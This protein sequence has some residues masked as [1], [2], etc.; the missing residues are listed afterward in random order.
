[1]HEGGIRVLKRYWSDYTSEEFSR[2]DRGSIVAVLPVG[3][4]E[5]H[6]PHLPLSVD[7]A[8][9]SG[10]VAAIVGRL[11]DAS[12]ALFLPTQP[13]GKSNEH[14]RYAGT[15]TFSAQTLISMWCEIGACVAASGVR[16]LV[17]LNS[18]GG[19]HHGHCRARVA[20]AS[21]H[22]GVLGQLVRA[23]AAGRSLR[24]S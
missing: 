16:K 12:R 8:I 9:V 2:L 21:R 7:S 5:Q 23:G 20:R 15:L 19:Q 17:L 22:D 14:A 4:T 6:G 24:R 18:H 13:I 10:M 1:M 11:P 3:A